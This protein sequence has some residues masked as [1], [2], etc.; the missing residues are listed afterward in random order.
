[1]SLLIC[2]SVCVSVCLSAFHLSFCHLS[3]LSVLTATHMH[4]HIYIHVH[5]LYNTYTMHIHVHTA[6]HVVQASIIHVRTYTYMHMCIYIQTRHTHHMFMLT[7][8]YICTALP[9]MCTVFLNNYNGYLGL[10]VAHGI[11]IYDNEACCFAH[12]ARR[13]HGWCG[14]SSHFLDLP[15]RMMKTSATCGCQAWTTQ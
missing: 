11:R 12:H 3:H 14:N 5:V 10:C 6:I 9:S 15:V 8:S 1:M 2:L 7:V 4:I 13:Y